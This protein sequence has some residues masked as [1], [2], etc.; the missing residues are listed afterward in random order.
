MCVS[1]N[2]R[3]CVCV[4]L[5]VNSFMNFAPQVF[6]AYQ[7]CALYPSFLWHFEHICVCAFVSVFVCASLCV[8]ARNS[9]LI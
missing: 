7:L 9:N 4:S 8:Y 1:A 2:A 6:I 5:R 3:A